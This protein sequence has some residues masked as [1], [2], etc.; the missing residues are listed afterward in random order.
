M[1]VPKIRPRNYQLIIE[2]DPE[3]TFNAGSPAK[4]PKHIIDSLQQKFAHLTA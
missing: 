3:P 4:A 1:V 2:Y